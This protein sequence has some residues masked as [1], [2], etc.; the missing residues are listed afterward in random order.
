MKVVVFSDTHGRHRNIIAMPPGDVLVF[1]GDMC[2]RETFTEV[3]NFSEWFS[4][5]PH[6]HKIVVAGNHDSP[7]KD[8]TMRSVFR[9]DGIVY[10]EDEEIVIDGIKFYG[11]PFTP[12]FYNWSFMLPEREL[13]SAKWRHIPEDTNVLLTHG[14]PAGT[15][16]KNY[17]M[18]NCGSVSLRKRITQLKDLKF[19]CFGHIHEGYGTYEDSDSGITYHNVSILNGKY[20]YQ[21]A[22]KKFEIGY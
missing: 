15:L 19:H 9:D 21:N 16:D 6:P 22:P 1:C 7:L 13:Y 20:R 4:S 8:A 5:H 12:L 2:N 3:A 18:Q 14:P 11:S 10:L 17:N